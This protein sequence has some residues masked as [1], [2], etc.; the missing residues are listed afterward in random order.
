[1]EL[2]PSYLEQRVHPI[3]LS[4]LTEVSV[5]CSTLKL[6]LNGFP[7]WLLT[8]SHSRTGLTPNPPYFSF[9]RMNGCQFSLQTSPTSY[10]L[11][12]QS[13]KLSFRG[14]SMKV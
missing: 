6:C 11:H 13:G 14:Q 4:F 1:M 12:K 7:M 3:P 8:V 9:E 10:V 5:I 2:L